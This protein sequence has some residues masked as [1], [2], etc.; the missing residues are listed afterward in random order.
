MKKN[1]P[2]KSACSVSI[3]LLQWRCYNGTTDNYFFEQ[4][5]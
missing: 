5:L 4:K 2:E 3:A 1:K